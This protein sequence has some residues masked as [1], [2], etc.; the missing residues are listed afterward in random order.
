MA[1]VNM[2]LRCTPLLLLILT[3]QQH[4]RD[5][6]LVLN[7][8]GISVILGIPGLRAFASQF[9]GFKNLAE[10]TIAIS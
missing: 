2:G 4:V 8:C 7:Y 3:G 5:T 9:K 6:S 10:A 1:P